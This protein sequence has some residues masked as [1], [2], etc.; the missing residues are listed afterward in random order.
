MAL[1]FTPSAFLFLVGVVLGTVVSGV[2][3]VYPLNLRSSI[4]LLG[5]SIFCLTWALFIFFL[6]DTLLIFNLPHLLHTN[7]ITTLLFMP[8]SYLFVRSVLHRQVL[9]YRDLIHGLPLLLYLVDYWPVYFLTEEE[10]LQI[11]NN[12][13]ISSVHSFVKGWVLPTTVQKPLR[14]LLFMLY[15]LLQ[16]RLIRSKDSPA[17]KWLISYLTA[18]IILL[19]GYVAIQF[20]LSDS[21]WLI[22]KVM[23]S[24]Y[25]IFVTFSLLLHP[26][27]LYNVN[28]IPP[29]EQR[30]IERIKKELSDSPAEEAGALSRS[31][32]ENIASR[33]ENLM[34]SNAPYLRHR[35]SIHD[36]S[37]Q[38]QV[39][40]Y[41]V[42]AFL[43]HH[44]GLSF[45]DYLNKH[46]IQY[47]IKKLQEHNR[48]LTVEA[49]AYECGFSN[50]NS[51][52]SAFK[53]FA[54]STPSE[55]MRLAKKS[56]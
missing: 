45:N 6:S 37:A 40:S 27:L 55:F 11:L 38:L 42:S 47:C 14:I 39:P 54:G 48:T 24:A 15:Y 13:G 51:F 25:I 2:C 23:L 31:T 3:W 34:S 16:W 49:L 50:R 46:R 28:K 22:I 44:L 1:T 30:L 56:G 8:F 52:T 43:N 41:Q 18:Q 4:Q 9:S 7:F 36:L 53:R 32:I 17:K 26:R 5:T 33:L 12:N 20:P 35:Y 19:L 21:T 29:E 10:K